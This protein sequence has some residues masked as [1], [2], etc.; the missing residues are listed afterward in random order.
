MENERTS[1]LVS[2]IRAC[3]QHQLPCRGEQLPSVGVIQHLFF[4]FSMEA[5]VNTALTSDSWFLGAC[6]NFTL[7]GL[8]A[9]EGL[10]STSDRSPQCKLLLELLL[11]GD[12]VWSLSCIIQSISRVWNGV[13]FLKFNFL[14]FSLTSSDF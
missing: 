5:H 6:T 14:N 13:L 1:L 9:Q 11:P 10:S 4:L 8:I 3:I 2:E 12:N 7:Q